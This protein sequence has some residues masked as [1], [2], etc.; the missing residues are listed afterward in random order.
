MNDLNTLMHAAVDDALP[1]LTAI[2]ATATREGRRLR[3]RRRIGYAGAGL[4]V[5]A[6]VA[7]AAVGAGN[8]AGGISGADLQP[9]ADGRSP[10][11][12]SS[13]AVPGPGPVTP[14]LKAGDILTLPHGLT[15]T[16]VPCTREKSICAPTGGGHWLGAS[17]QPGSGE[18]LAVVISGPAGAASKFWSN[19]FGNLT[20]RYPGITVA[21]SDSVWSAINPAVYSGQDVAI[22]LAGWKQVGGVADDKQTLEGPGGAVADIVWRPASDYASWSSMKND[23]T[24]WRSAVHD[25]VFVTIQG[26]LGTTTAQVRALGASLTWK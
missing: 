4:A 14:A 12:S 10:A 3:R 23:P 1:D 16:V 26:G 6:V 8:L 25:G 7:G 9:A 13:A 5:A 11:A 19:G 15:G 20:G 18:G 22:H 24:T 2:A 21:V 17:N